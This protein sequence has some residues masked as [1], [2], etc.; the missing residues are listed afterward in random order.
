VVA[1]LA[2]LWC[3]LMHP[4]LGAEAYLSVE[5]KELRVGQIAQARVVLTDAKA[6][7][8]PSIPDSLNVRASYVG[9]SS[10]NQMT[11]QGLSGYTQ[12]NYRIIPLAAGDFQVGPVS[13][14]VNGSPVQTQAVSLRVRKAPV[15]KDEKL[16]LQAGFIPSEA[17]EGQVVLYH[18]SLASEYPIQQAPS[19]DLDDFSSLRPPRDGDRPQRVDTRNEEGKELQVIERWMP[20]VVMGAQDREFRAPL[21][22]IAVQP[23]TGGRPEARLL[24]GEST[25]LPV[26]PLPPIEAEFSGLVGE[27]TVHSE[28]DR[29]ALKAGESVLWRVRIEGNGTLESVDLPALPPE[30]PVQVYDGSVTAT[31]AVV[32]SAYRAKLITER[33]IVPVQEGRLELPTLILRSFSPEKGAYVEHPLSFPVLEVAPGA[34]GAGAALSFAPTAEPSDLLPIPDPLQ[35]IRSPMRSRGFQLAASWPWLLALLALAG[36]GELAREPIQAL[37]RWRSQRAKTEVVPPT[38]LEVLDSLPADLG[39]RLSAAERAL[40]VVGTQLPKGPS[41][42]AARRRHQALVDRLH[43]V[44]FAG[45]PAENCIDEIRSFIR[46]NEKGVTG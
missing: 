36:L 31:A 5:P 28:L 15:K 41:G 4:A 12:Y 10:R 46:D 1:F 45:A 9:S 32:D 3:V 19:W 30:V 39:S 8:P 43:R 2:V 35:P 29:T 37:Q 27:F 16:R 17:W 18:Y 21:A 24:I 44:R 34:V 13:I 23:P 42:E 7:N 6:D 20:F 40:R 33:T 38:A 14:Q 26:R 25:T 11:P 22:Q